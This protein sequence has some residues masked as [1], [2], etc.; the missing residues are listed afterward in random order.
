M[1]NVSMHVLR[2]ASVAA[3]LLA[4]SCAAP[5]NDGSV[6][7]DGLANHPITV[8]PHF[9]SIRV[10]FS[11]A[12]AGL[13]PEEGAQ[14]E[15]FV[16][17]YLSRGDGSI[18]VSAPRGPNSTAALTWFGERLARMGVP[19]AR[20]MVGTRDTADG[21]GRV[22][23]GYI[24]YAA[25]TDRC[26]NWSENAGD[27]EGNLPMPDFGCSVQ[28]NVAAMI[29]DPRDLVAPRGMDAGDATR[30]Q[31]VIGTYEQAKSTSSQKTSD[32]SGAV[33]AASTGSQ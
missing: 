19:R 5:I 24:V 15:G 30:R 28:H 27:T 2:A 6:V 17:D 20:I 33:S 10:A 18:S 14:L 13:T 23:I 29:A 3:V 12:S 7:A 31:T 26:G 4:G 32:Q 21:D 16:G 8:A 1:T 22:E 25:R 9:Q 11:D